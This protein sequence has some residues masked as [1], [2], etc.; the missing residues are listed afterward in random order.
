MM[1]SGPASEFE[2]TAVSLVDVLPADEVD[3][4]LDAGFLAELGGIGAEHV[5]VGLDE[6]Y[7][8]QHPQGRALL[9]REF[10]AGTS[11]A[12]MVEAVCADAPVMA[13]VAADTPRARASRRV[14]SFVM[15]FSLFLPCVD[16]RW[17]WQL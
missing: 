16:R 6:A 2:V 14:M 5:F 11:A 15:V 4:D 8:A 3:L 1:M 13:S 12:L 9:D 7:R 10:G 17:H